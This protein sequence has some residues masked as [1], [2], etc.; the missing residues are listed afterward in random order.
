[1]SL[2]LQNIFSSFEIGK[3]WSFTLLFSIVFYFIISVFWRDSRSFFLLSIF[4]TV[5]LIISYSWASHPA[6]LSQWSGLINHFIHFTSVCVWVG[7]LFL[8]GWFSKD[9]SNWLSFLR[10]YTPLSIICLSFT[11]I[12]GFFIMTMIIDFSEYTS[13][14]LVNYGQSLLIKH[15]FIIPIFLF[16]FTNSFLVKRRL[17]SEKA[18]NPI[19]WVR[20]EGILLLCIFTATSVLSQQEPPHD[21]ETTVKSMGISPFLALLNSSITIDTVSVQLQFTLTTMLLFS[22]ALVFLFTTFLA[23][24]KRVSAYISVL[25]GLLSALSIYLALMSGVH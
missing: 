21:I 5:I 7:I 12:S 22:L 4:F 9:T 10:W 3:A 2:T 20:A 6:S 19:P 1:M 13:S 17:K 23:F 14:W 16:A 8:V 15:I 18:F 11:M 25:L 24:K